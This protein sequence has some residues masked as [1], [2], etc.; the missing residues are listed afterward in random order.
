MDE[1]PASYMDQGQMDKES[2]FTYSYA[3]ANMPDGWRPNEG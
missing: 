3:I 2:F 1:P